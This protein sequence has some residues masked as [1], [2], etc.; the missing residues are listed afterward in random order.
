MAKIVGT[1]AHTYMRCLVNKIKTM[2]K[3][4]DIIFV[5]F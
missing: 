5:P 3:Q 2:N 1:L 4:R